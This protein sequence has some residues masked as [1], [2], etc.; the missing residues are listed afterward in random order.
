MQKEWLKAR[1]IEPRVTTRHWIARLGRAFS[2]IGF[3]AGTLFFIAS[4]TPSLIPRTYLTQGVLSGVSLAAGYGVGVF[5]DWLW[6]YLEFPEPSPRVER[7]IKLV[8]AAACVVA[9]VVLLWEASQWQNSIRVRMEIEPVETAR[10]FRVGLIAFAVFGVLYGVA[11]IFQLTAHLSSAW[12][13]RHI[14]HRMSNLI[15]VAVAVSLFW[16]LIDGVLIRYGLRMTDFSF[17]QFDKLMESGVEAPTD[18]LKTGS[19]A[20]LID[21]EEGLGRAGRR[22]VS[23]GPTRQRIAAFTGEQA[24]KPIRVYVGLNAAETVEER[25]KLAL[26]ELKRTGAFERSILIIATP[27][28]KGTLDPGAINTVE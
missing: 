14:P 5:I 7:I 17:K 8:T 11:R 25:A 24:R 15:G 19:E 28:G 16:L 23:T 12:L 4:L 3:L 20:S 26:E 2:G 21:W 18:P 9:A 13:K 27:T 1:K 6:G 10:P 22:F